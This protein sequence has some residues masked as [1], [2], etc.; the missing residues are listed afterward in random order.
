MPQ[1][2]QLNTVVMFT[3]QPFEALPSQLAKFDEHDRPH[4][5]MAQNAVELTPDGHTREQ[6]PQVRGLERRSDS[7]PLVA[8]LSQLAKLA[9][10]ANEH[11][12]P[13]QV[14]D[15][16]GGVGHTRPQEPQLETLV[17]RSTQLEP[18]T[19]SPGAQPLRHAP[20]EHC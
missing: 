4:A 5:P 7:Q 9:L 3:S 8:L 19:V 10:Q 11:A 18:Q 20:L 2:P 1:R 6:L 13:L 16:L 17:R 15:E 12:P 14:E